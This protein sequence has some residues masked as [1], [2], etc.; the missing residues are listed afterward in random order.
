[1]TSPSEE[2]VPGTEREFERIV[3]GIRPPDG[4]WERR[5]WERLDSLTKP[6]RS[7]GRLEEL[8]AKVA[9]IQETLAPSV[10]RKRIVLMAAD[11]G[12]VAEGV[13]PYPQ[14]V[15][16]QMVANFSAG[17][18]AINQLAES[19][20]AELVLVDMGV[21]RDLSDLAGVVHAK[22][23]LGTANLATG[24]AMTREMA[25]QAL[26]TGARLASQAAADGVLL[27]GTGDM[28]I[29]NTT[30]AAAL[31][32]AFTDADPYAVAGPGTGLD[33]AGVRHKASVVRQA[34][35][36]NATRLNDPLGVLAAVGG[37]EIAGLAGVVLGA[38]STHTCVV[39]DGFISGAAALTA[40]RLCPQA[41]GYVFPSHRSAEPGHSVVLD[42]LDLSPV[43][44]LDMR[45]GEGS[46]AALAFAIVDA[47]CRV[48][49]G[50]ATF[51]EAGV[52]GAKSDGADGSQSAG[53]AHA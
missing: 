11:H 16:W 39:V 15:T 4:R 41:Q 30:A 51:A 33:S 20:G 21:A 40:I 17:G 22:V 48:M 6:P 28:G 36:V 37:L 14:D 1:M 53:S 23:A 19:V 38:A 13:S 8:A 45:L 50:M 25:I 34:L 44:D 31:T 52:D 3:S 5:A 24:P 27:I 46:G 47:A 35:K 12:V 29:G 43:L 49:S 9:C 42:A 10:D 18:A 26:L 7:L 32:C 2:A